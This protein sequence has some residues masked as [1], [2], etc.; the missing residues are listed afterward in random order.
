MIAART[1]F[2][3]EMEPVPATTR[4]VKR[5]TVTVEIDRADAGALYNFIEYATREMM[6]W[7]S[8]A[9]PGSSGI[10]L[11][12]TNGRTQGR[13]LAEALSNLV[14]HGKWNASKRNQ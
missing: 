14:G 2:R 12:G 5:D 10:E 3:T 6:G 9:R 1:S 13:E 4:E 11:Y 8:D 7:R